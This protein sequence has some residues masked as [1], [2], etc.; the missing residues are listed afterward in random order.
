MQT[1]C[2]VL[3]VCHLNQFQQLWEL[4]EA[5]SFSGRG[6]GFFNLKVLGNIGT[7]FGLCIGVQMSGFSW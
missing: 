2:W 1:V 3:C 4:R 5:V 7:K 6:M